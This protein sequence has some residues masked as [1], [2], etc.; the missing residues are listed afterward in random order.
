MSTPSFTPK[1]RAY[2]LDA[3]VD[4]RHDAPMTEKT[5]VP[6]G[7][8]LKQRRIDAGLTVSALAEACG[9]TPRALRYIES[10]ESMPSL[11]VAVSLAREVKV[12]LKLLVARAGL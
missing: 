8:W 5:K 1:L 10:G 11:E 3:E 12:S 6:F 4:F 9:I 7:G 2:L